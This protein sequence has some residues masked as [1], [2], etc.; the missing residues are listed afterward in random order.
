MIFFTVKNI[1]CRIV[2]CFAAVLTLSASAFEVEWSGQ[3]GAALAPPELTVGASMHQGFPVIKATAVVDGDYQGIGGTFKEAVDLSKYSGVRLFIRNNFSEGGCVVRFSCK[4]AD[5]SSYGTYA[6]CNITGNWTEITIPFNPVLWEATEG[7]KTFDFAESVGIYPFDAMNRKGYELEIA[8]FQ[9]IEHSTVPA[10]LTVQ[11]YRYINAPASGDNNGRALTDGDINT[12][13]YWPQYSDD[14]DVIFDLGGIFAVTDIKITANSIPAHNFAQMM[15]TSS[16]D[17]NDYY[18]VAVLQNTS[19]NTE[20]VIHSVAFEGKAIGR[21]FRFRAVKPRPDF[22][23]HMGEVSFSGYIPTA[24]EEAADAANRYVLGPEIAPRDSSEYVCVTLGD[25]TLW[26]SSVSGVVNGVQYKDDLWIERMAGYYV[27]QSRAADTPVSGYNDQVVDMQT[28]DG[29]IY[30]AL[31]NPDLPGILLEKWYYTDATG[32]LLETVN[33]LATENMPREFLQVSTDVILNRDFRETG[34]YETSASGHTMMR[35]FASEVRM[36]TGADNVPFLS[37]ENRAHNVTMLHTRIAANGEFIYLDSC[38][39]PDRLL[40][41]LANGWRMPMLCAV[42]V[43]SLEQEISATLRLSITEGGL[44]AAYDDYIS[45]PDVAAYRAGIRRADWLRDQMI[46]GSP[47][48]DGLCKGVSERYFANQNLLFDR[49]WYVS[50]MRE[51]LDFRWGEFPTEGIVED[52]F[53]GQKD[54]QELA[55]L[56]ARVREI[57]PNLKQGLYT[58]LWSSFYNQKI[59]EEHPEWFVK[60]SRSGS[61]ANFFPGVNTNWLRF[62][63]DDSIDEAVTSLMAMIRRYKLDNWYLDGGNG[64]SYTKDFSRMLIDDPHGPHKLYRRMREELQAYD[65]DAFIMFNVPLNPL[66]DAGFLESFSGVMTSEWRRGAAWM[67]KFK[68]T[69][70]KDP[71]HTPCYIYWLPSVDGAFHNYMLGTGLMP[72]A[73]SREVLPGEVAYI[74]ARY[75]VRQLSLTDA[76]QLPDWRSDAETE[77]ELMALTQNNAGFVFINH[78]GGAETVNISAD[79]APLGMNDTALPVHSWLMTFRNG[80]TWKGWWGQ[81]DMVEGYTNSRWI[82]E[83]SMTGE[84]LGTSQLQNRMSME[85]TF[86]GPQ[87]YMWVVSQCPAVIWSLDHLPSQYRIPSTPAAE[88]KGSYPDFTYATEYSASEIAFLVPAGSKIS[89]I[90]V[91]GRESVFRYGRDGNALLAIVEISSA[92]THDISV[93]LEDNTSYTAVRSV[94]AELS[95]RTLSGSATADGTDLTVSIYSD[96]ALCYTAPVNSDGRFAVEL[97]GTVKDGSYN[98][99]VSNLAGDSR[100]ET[101]L[102]ISGLGRPTILQP[103]MPHIETEHEVVQQTAGSFVTATGIEYTPTAAFANAD[104]VT[105]KLDVGT[106]PAITTQYS[107]SAAGLEFEAERYVEIEISSNLLYYNT[108]GQEPRRHFIRN[109]HPSSV[110]ALMF[111]FHTAGGY[112]TRT[113]AGLGHQYLNRGASP[114]KWGTAQAPDF[115]YALCN[116]IQDTEKET[117]RFW[118]DTRQLGAPANW[119]GKIWLTLIFQIGAPNRQLSARVLNTSATLPAGVN[120]LQGIQLQTEAEKLTFKV[121]D[122][123]ADTVVTDDWNAPE[124]QTIAELPSMTLISPPNMPAP[125][126]SK[127]RVAKD[128]DNLYIFTWFKEEPGRVLETEFGANGLPWLSDSVEFWIQTKAGGEKMIHGIVDADYHSYCDIGYVDKT[129]NSTDILT[130]MPFQCSIRRNDDHWTALLTLPLSHLQGSPLAF[131]IMRNRSKTGSLEY[132]TTVPG[133]SYFCGETYFLEF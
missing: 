47:G 44:L 75:E 74:S 77:T 103:L 19:Q 5:G 22:K 127:S 132:Y 13:A 131:N 31:T 61:V 15:I 67:W 95:G 93:E 51:D 62:W 76:N 98:I 21:Y 111:D 125:F 102:D 114:D 79:T 1:F 49:G 122:F 112:T 105:A 118:I 66:S 17:G 25:F 45:Q 110:A 91:D 52:W 86:E 54:A 18:P 24:A 85:M 81:P 6:V 117:M 101:S 29:F 64:G 124:W 28:G 89:S 48:W 121:Q 87:A 88:I 65:P 38:V 69:Q 32:A 8:G 30:L 82:G 23:V 43:D 59:V 106:L 11:A 115:F 104:A 3:T 42:P 58:W 41:F 26:I 126:L 119:D 16:I 97:P 109:D 116:F 55:D 56:L 100:A 84:Y 133:G 2:L 46:H 60:E 71:Y 70:Y 10:P 40:I 37:F 27:R 33:V 68:M 57:C 80:K 123:A 73:Y 108:N 96:N 14:G 12:Q 34:V 7:R 128:R 9:F 92:G 130:E 39:D 35:E 107:T 94:T 78:H 36:Q 83:S 4:A 50:A 120:V 63:T 53:G 72:T 20:E 113:L 129:N 99:V 90:A